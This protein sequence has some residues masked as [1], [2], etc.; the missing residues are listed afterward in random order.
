[1]YRIK[2]LFRCSV[3]N[4][5]LVHNLIS[6]QN[7]SPKFQFA[8][9][10]ACDAKVLDDSD[11]F[12]VGSKFV[13]LESNRGSEPSAEFDDPSDRFGTLAKKVDDT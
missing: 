6:K 4:L 13:K 1:M 5:G 12:G 7:T 10:Q 8:R 2:S 9:T 3:R 11:K